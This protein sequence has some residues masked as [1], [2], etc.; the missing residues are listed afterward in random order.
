M[1]R[2]KNAFKSCFRRV[3]MRKLLRKPDAVQASKKI[4]RQEGFREEGSGMQM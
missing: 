1:I 2:E 3:I 4:S